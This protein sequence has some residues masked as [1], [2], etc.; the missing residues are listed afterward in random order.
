MR[1]ATLNVWGIRGDWP[2]RLP[3]LRD[4]FAAI[5]ADLVTLQ[6]TIRTGTQDQAREI[7]GDD[8]RLVHQ[9]KREP[10][11]QGVTTASRWPVGT[12]I[13]ADLNVTDRTGGFACTSLVTEILA[14]RPV[15]RVWLASASATATRGH[16][17]TPPTQATPTAPITPTAPTGT[18]PTG[19]STT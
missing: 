18:G 4:G 19:G 8:Y 2:A 12:V 15:G 16:A 14:P 11:G 6:E 3:L 17:R 13:E 7:L 5:A 1:V 10:D 9:V